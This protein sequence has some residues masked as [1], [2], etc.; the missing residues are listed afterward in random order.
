M[1]SELEPGPILLLATYTP[2]QRAQ[3]IAPFGGA[4]VKLWDVR[5]L[6]E[7]AWLHDGEILY[8]VHAAD[9][10]C[11][12]LLAA[13]SGIRFIYEWRHYGDQSLDRSM[14]DRLE[15]LVMPNHW[16]EPHGS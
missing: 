4:D 7:V 11:A 6:Y 9:G 3:A 1:A 8:V 12:S 10:D 16:S 15:L 2:G 14:S 13:I 5:P